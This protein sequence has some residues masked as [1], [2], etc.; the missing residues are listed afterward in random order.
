MGLSSRP[1]GWVRRCRKHE[2][3]RSRSRRR[4]GLSGRGPRGEEA[5]SNVDQRHRRYGIREGPHFSQKGWVSAE[6]LTTVKWIRACEMDRPTLR[7]VTL[8]GGGG[9]GR[10]RG[11]G[12]R[13]ARETPEAASGGGRSHPAPGAFHPPDNPPEMKLHKPTS[14]CLKQLLAGAA[15]IRRQVPPR[16]QE[17]PKDLSAEAL[18]TPPAPPAVS[19]PPQVAHREVGLRPNRGYPAGRRGDPLVI[20]H[21]AP[22]A[23][24][25]GA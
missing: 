22:D 15:V 4:L 20:E 12:G 9:G 23:R 19:A 7:C 17:A 16:D 2:R 14:G 18:G 25:G 6:S 24:S 10:L 13:G 8:R 21:P 1:D 3:M 11:Q 5:R